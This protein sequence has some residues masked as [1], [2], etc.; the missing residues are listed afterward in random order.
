MPRSAQ[1]LRLT[2]RYAAQLAATE[3][4]V[5]RIAN[6]RWNLEPS[7][8]DGSY[9]TWLDVVVPVVTAAQRTNER[10]TTAYLTAFITSETRTRP[11]LKPVESVAGTSRDGRPLR[12]AWQSPPITAKVAISEG[13]SVAEATEAA[14]TDALRRVNLDTYHGA[15]GTMTALLAAVTAITGYSRVTG[16]DPCGACLGLADGTVLPT[17]EAFELH[18]NCDCVAEPVLMDVPNRVQRP[19]GQ[20]IFNELSRKKQ[21]EL[22]GEEAAEAV[23]G[24]VPLSSLVGHAHMDAEADWITQ[25]PL[26]AL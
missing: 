2:D 6:S 24:G 12:E 22:L 18:A 14:R 11:R 15:R 1:S 4:R 26:A 5:A 25:K 19:T 21:V 23:R 7:D 13:K 10:L 8:F 20:E 9:E 3:A 17:D 16:G